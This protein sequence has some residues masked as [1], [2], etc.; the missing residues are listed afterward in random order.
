MSVTLRP[1]GTHPAICNLPAGHS[2]P[3]NGF[4]KVCPH[5]ITGCSVSCCPVS[6]VPQD[7]AK[8]PVAEQSLGQYIDKRLKES[9]GLIAD[10]KELKGRVAGLSLTASRLTREAEQLREDHQAAL[11]ALERVQATLRPEREATP[12]YPVCSVCGGVTAL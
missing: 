7:R 2:E 5:G 6:E 8:R 4:S 11:T 10:N 1:D 3:C 12:R 9:D